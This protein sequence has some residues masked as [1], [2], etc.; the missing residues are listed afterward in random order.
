MRRLK[1]PRKCLFQVFGAGGAAFAALIA[2]AENIET[3]LPWT[4]ATWIIVGS[5]VAS[6][7]GFEVLCQREQGD[8]DDK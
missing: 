5:F 4:A 1:D 7:W 3:Y 2:S 6:L 8:K